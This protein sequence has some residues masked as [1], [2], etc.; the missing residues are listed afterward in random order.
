MNDPT[1]DPAAVAAPGAADVAADKPA[2]LDPGSPHAV[3]LTTPE[4]VQAHIDVNTATAADMHKNGAP[5]EYTAAWLHAQLA[6]LC[7]DLKM[8]GDWIKA[9]L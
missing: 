6:G 2:D 8:A 7:D 5:F 1:P 4:G 9:K 3:D